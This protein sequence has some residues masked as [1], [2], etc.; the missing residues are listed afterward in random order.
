[1]IVVLVALGIFLSDASHL[2]KD[3]VSYSCPLKHRGD[4]IMCILQTRQKRDK[5][6]VFFQRSHDYCELKLNQKP[7][8]K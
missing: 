4:T 6:K 7:G 1:L 2:N 3:A 5:E 8:S